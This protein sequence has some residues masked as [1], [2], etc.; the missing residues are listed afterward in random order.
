MRDSMY[1]ISQFFSC[2]AKTGGSM[3][4][5]SLGS[6]VEQLFGASTSKEK[7]KDVKKIVTSIQYFWPAVRSEIIRRKVE[8]HLPEGLFLFEGENIGLL[9]GSL[10]SISESEI[11]EIIRVHANSGLNEKEQEKALTLTTAILASKYFN[12]MVS[13]VGALLKN[14][15]ENNFKRY[16]VVGNLLA[17]E[18][19]LKMPDW[20]LKEAVIDQ[21]VEKIKEENSSKVLSAKPPTSSNFSEL[22]ETEGFDSEGEWVKL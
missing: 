21:M 10:L 17:K 6:E 19:S 3:Y 9:K 5:V 13:A 1:K 12:Q 8:D 18:C 14:H 16:E 7:S 4:K 20:V 22:E 11:N 2:D 15:I